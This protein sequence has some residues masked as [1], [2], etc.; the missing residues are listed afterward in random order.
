[1]KKKEMFP[2]N[3]NKENPTAARGYI[4][5]K[6]AGLNYS[7]GDIKERQWGI[8]IVK[9]HL[10]SHTHTHMR[11]ATKIKLSNIMLFVCVLGICVTYMGVIS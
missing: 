5:R 3:S 9:L 4:Q 8:R 10:L 1:M 2:L 7:F 11:A 6:Q